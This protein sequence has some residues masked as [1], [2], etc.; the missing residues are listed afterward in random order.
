M[1]GGL[2]IELGYLHIWD[3]GF[4]DRRSIFFFFNLFL[5]WFHSRK[6][7]FKR[8]GKIDENFQGKGTVNRTG[9]NN[10]QLTGVESRFA[11]FII[12]SF[13]S[14]C[15]APL[16]QEW[17]WRN[18]FFSTGMT[19]EVQWLWLLVSY[20][21]FLF[22]WTLMGERKTHNVIKNMSTLTVAGLWHLF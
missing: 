3:S 6:V 5:S 11:F 13:P 4:G 19:E 22:P 21:Q 8:P 2:I 18:C 17:G 9:L 7:E 15:H 12:S 20:W 10:C 14:F 1:K 16:A